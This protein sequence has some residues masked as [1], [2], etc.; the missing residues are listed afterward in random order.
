MPKNIKSIVI[1]FVLACSIFYMFMQL[2]HYVGKKKLETQYPLVSS[3]I[4]EPADWD[5]EEK[6]LM[7]YLLPKCKAENESGNAERMKSCWEGRAAAIT[8]G[9]KSTKILNALLDKK[10]IN[11]K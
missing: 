11:K 3:L 6:E 10:L 7:A 1:F 5:S 8:D 4:G 2:G 9:G